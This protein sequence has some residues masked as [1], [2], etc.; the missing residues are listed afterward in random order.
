MDYVDPVAAYLRENTSPQDKVF[1]WGFRPVINFVS[2][3]ESPASFLPYPLVHVKTPLAQHWADQFYT[4]FTTN[5]PTLIVNMIDATDKA[6]IPDL[7]TTVRKQTKIKWQD[8]ILAHNFGD[9]LQFVRLNYVRITTVDGADIY[10]L[11]TTMP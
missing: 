9:I 3:R 8:V 1:I 11:K 6:R 2:D 7:D 5:P 4:Q 10:R